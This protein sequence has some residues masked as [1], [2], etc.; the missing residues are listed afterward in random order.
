MIVINKR[1]E[2]R[3]VIQFCQL[4]H[5][6]AR[7]HTHTHTSSHATADVCCVSKRRALREGVG[8]RKQEILLCTCGVNM[9][10]W[11]LCILCANCFQRE[12]TSS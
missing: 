2:L 3:N 10:V 4:T 12:D 7:T 6:L 11:A 5:S 1:S 9:F 8:R